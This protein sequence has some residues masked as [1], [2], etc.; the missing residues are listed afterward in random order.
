MGNRSHFARA[1]QTR[2]R[3]NE[4]QRFAEENACGSPGGRRSPLLFP[5]GMFPDWCCD[6]P[7][8]GTG[9]LSCVVIKGKWVQEALTYKFPYRCRDFVV[10]F[11][12]RQLG[13]TVIGG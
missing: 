5:P 1:R 7:Y 3:Q 8:R 4:H 11:I 6:K 10:E 12:H 2:H 9:S 13:E